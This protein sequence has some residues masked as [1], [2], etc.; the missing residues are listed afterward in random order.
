MVFVSRRPRVVRFAASRTRSPLRLLVDP[1][2]E[3]HAL[4]S[5]PR[6]ARRPPRGPRTGSWR[7]RPRST[8]PCA[9]ARAAGWARRSRGSCS[10]TRGRRPPTPRPRP[11]AGRCGSA[12]GRGPLSS[13]S[14]TVLVGSRPTVSVSPG[15][16]ST[17]SSR[18]ADVDDDE[19]W[20]WRR[21]SSARRRRRTPGVG[22]RRSPYRDPC[23]PPATRIPLPADAATS[24]RASGRGR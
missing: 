2:Q 17:V 9:R 7:C 24:G 3:A 1:L 13:G 23:R 12:A 14:G 22:P 5:R 20:P 16:S 8:S 19:S 15:A 18:R 21:R 6:Q 10:W 11:R 4:A